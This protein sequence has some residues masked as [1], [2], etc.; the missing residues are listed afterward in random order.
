MAQYDPY[1]ENMYQQ[2]DGQ[3]PYQ[4][5]P[6]QEQPYQ[7][8]TPQII[9]LDNKD[10]NYNGLN[11]PNYNPNIGYS[12]NRFQNDQVR[13][14]GGNP[15]PT[16]VDRRIHI[17]V[18]NQERMNKNRKSCLDCIEKVN[19]DYEQQAFVRKVFGILTVQFLFTVIL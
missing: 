7:G 1:G 15:Y 14:I 12:E 11:T 4:G 8:A 5:Q 18:D 10:Q 3:Q 2:Y 16:A 13:N 17:E 9:I 6:Y 19:G